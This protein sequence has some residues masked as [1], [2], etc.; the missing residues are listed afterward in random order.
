MGAR[1][2][3]AEKECRQQVEQ[4]RLRQEEATRLQAL[5]WE[6]ANW[7]RAKQI[8]AYVEAVRQAAIERDG[9]IE[10]EGHLDSWLVWALR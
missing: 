7:Q 5:E 4:E 3:V 10:A 1:A 9:A 2:P 6:V 8:R